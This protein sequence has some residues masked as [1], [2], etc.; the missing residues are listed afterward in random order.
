MSN[1]LLSRLIYSVD[2]ISYCWEDYC[3]T[4]QLK[5]DSNVNDDNKLSHRYIVTHSS[6]KVQVVGWYRW[7][8]APAT[9]TPQY[10]QH[11]EGGSDGIQDGGVLE[12]LGE[13]NLIVF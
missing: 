13:V 9:H 11:Q 12:T 1:S 8:T 7:L 3:Y 5:W 6:D 10:R 4:D 2:K